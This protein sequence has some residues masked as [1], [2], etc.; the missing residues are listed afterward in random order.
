MVIVAV[1]RAVI[2]IGDPALKHKTLA[3]ICGALT[4]DSPP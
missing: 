1:G 3:D 2:G 4:R